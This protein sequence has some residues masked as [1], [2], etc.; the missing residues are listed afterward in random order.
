MLEGPKGYETFEFQGLIVERQFIVIFAWLLLIFFAWL[1][2]K[3][4]LVNE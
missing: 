3:P 1:L 4:C 2:L